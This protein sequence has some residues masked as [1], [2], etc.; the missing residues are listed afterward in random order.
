MT[1]TA[2]YRQ[3]ELSRGSR[4]MASFLRKRLK[5]KWPEYLR[6]RLVLKRMLLSERAKGDPRATIDRTGLMAPAIRGSNGGLLLCRTAPPKEKRVGPLKVLAGKR[7][8][9]SSGIPHFAKPYTRDVI[10]TIRM[11]TFPLLHRFD[12][13]HERAGQLKLLKESTRRDKLAPLYR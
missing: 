7:T 3:D 5:K 12:E 4:K 11:S 2:I 10:R 8:R 9:N 6:S 1:T 13:G